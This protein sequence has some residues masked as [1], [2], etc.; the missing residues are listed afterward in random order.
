MSRYFS[1][2]LIELKK[3]GGERGEGETGRK[4]WVCTIR[5]RTGLRKQVRQGRRTRS[6][7]VRE[8]PRPSRDRKSV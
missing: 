6:V 2:R 8:V 4:T 5:N 3:N 1:L 7:T